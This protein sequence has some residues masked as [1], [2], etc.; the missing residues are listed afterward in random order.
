M[1]ISNEPCSISADVSSQASHLNN[2]NHYSSPITSP[3]NVAPVTE[4]KQSSLDSNHSN[5]WVSP[6]MILDS[7]KVL[8]FWY[9]SR[10]KLESRD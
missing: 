3:D 5:F 4:F 9:D 10:R 6:D 7:S 2:D 8:Y 1:K